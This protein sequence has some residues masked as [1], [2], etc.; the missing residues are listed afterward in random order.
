MTSTTPAGRVT[1]HDRTRLSVHVGEARTEGVRPAPSRRW[2]RWD[3]RRLPGWAQALL[4]L[5]ASRVLTSFVAHRSADLATPHAGGRHWGYWEIANNWDG[6]WY[7]RA[8]VQGY[9][10]TLPIDSATG[11]VAPSTWAFYPLYPGTVRLLQT[12][13]GLSWVVAA[14]IVSVT[15]AG[16]AVVVVRALLAR[17]AGPRAALW[18]VAFLVFWP[19]AAVLQL[20]YSESLA[21]LVL[22]GALWCLQRRRYLALVPVLLLLGV[23]RPVAVPMGV[24]LVAHALRCGLE[25][26]GLP[27]GEAARRLA[28]PAAALVAGAVAAVEWPAA[29]W[30]RTG[31][32]DAYTLTMAAWRTPPQIVPVRPWI[33]A[34]QLYLGEH[35]GP[36]ALVAVLG[37]LAGWLVRRGVAV[38]GPDLTVW[39]AAYS[40][41]LLAVLDSFT[42]LPRYLL[43]LFPLGALLARASPSRAFR[44]AVTV[45]LAAMGVVWMLAVWRSRIW[46]P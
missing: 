14:T 3:P 46:A 37:A 24:V 16:G 41:Y 11:L 8:G 32:P 13:T 12:L 22:A 4:L 36:V 39:C 19:S 7:E 20:P 27:R 5:A 25:V 2:G 44:V 26:R 29:A 42:S 10:A 18:A 28:G 45:A 33:G 17:V 31:V 15:A 6:T 38:I 1:D 21:L 43:P 30:W 23:A 35:V 40:A 9:P 34:S